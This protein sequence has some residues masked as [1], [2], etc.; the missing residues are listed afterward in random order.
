L[1]VAQHGIFGIGQN[2]VF[3][4]H[5]PIECS[6]VEAHWLDP[7]TKYAK[8]LHHCVKCKAVLIPKLKKETN[9]FAVEFCCT[10]FHGKRFQPMY[11]FVQAT[12]TTGRRLKSAPFILRG[13]R[14]TKADESLQYIQNRANKNRP[15]PAPAPTSA[16]A[17]AAPAPAPAPAILMPPLAQEPLPTTVHDN[18]DQGN[19]ANPPSPTLNPELPTLP[20]SV[21]AC[22][23]GFSSPEDG[24]SSTGQELR[25]DPLDDFRCGRIDN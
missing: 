13:S 10:G 12:S 3:R 16:P 1:V 22:F 2:I 8:Q 5:E 18:Q 23:E 14:S 21:P 7:S 17:A 20:L 25:N 9:K 19:R 24:F 11:V 15:S 6:T 4:S